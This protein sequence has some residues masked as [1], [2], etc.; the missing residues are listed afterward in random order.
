MTKSRLYIHAVAS[1]WLFTSTSSTTYAALDPLRQYMSRGIDAVEKGDSKSFEASIDAIEVTCY[2]LTTQA[3]IDYS[4]VENDPNIGPSPKLTFLQRVMKW[5]N[6][7]SVLPT[8]LSGLNVLMAPFLLR[9]SD[10]NASLLKLQAG[11]KQHQFQSEED[12][13]NNQ[14][15]DV[16]ETI[17][18][19]LGQVWA[20]YETP[21]APDPLAPNTHLYED[22]IEESATHQSSSEAVASGGFFDTVLSVT[23]RAAVSLVRKADRYVRG[24][25]KREQYEGYAA[26]PIASALLPDDAMKPRRQRNVETEKPPYGK[27]V[28]VGKQADESDDSDRSVS[29][30]EVIGGTPRSASIPISSSLSRSGVPPQ[31]LA[32]SPPASVSASVSASAP[33]KPSRVLSSTPQQRAQSTPQRIVTGFV[34]KSQSSWAVAPERKSSEPDVPSRSRTI[35]DARDEGVPQTPPSSELVV[36]EAQQSS[37]EV[38]AAPIKSQSSSS[39]QEEEV[40][41]PLSPANDDGVTLEVQPTSHHEPEASEPQSA[42]FVSVASTPLLPVEDSHDSVPVDEATVGGQT[43]TQSAL[44][45]QIADVDRQLEVAQETLAKGPQ[46]ANNKTKK[47]NQ[48]VVDG[49]IATRDALLRQKQQVETKP[50]KTGKK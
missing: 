29:P 37:H 44:E 13:I 4:A 11:K 17:A 45:T 43:P 7:M 39:I 41:P 50:E 24:V 14:I 32:S 27:N 15:F 23:G 6:L 46:G 9:R 20:R 40:A 5:H 25:T 2:E 10:L 12:K 18:D 49:L 31:S 16:N 38:P 30:H 33:A 34:G 21:D 42:E 28:E 19:L 47:A 36:N 1:L 3:L 8:D 48:K 35:S 22:G 26:S